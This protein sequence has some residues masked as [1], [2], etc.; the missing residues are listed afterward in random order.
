MPATRPS[1]PAPLVPTGPAVP[2][3]GPA[4]DEADARGLDLEAPEGEGEA[5]LLYRIRRQ[6][7]APRFIPEEGD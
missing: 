5:S 4:E 3:A 2:T 7:S 1:E 6:R